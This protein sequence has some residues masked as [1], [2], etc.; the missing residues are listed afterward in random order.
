MCWMIQQC[1]YPS[2]EGMSDMNVKNGILVTIGSFFAW[3]L[4]FG[5]YFILFML[6]ERM[7]NQSGSYRFVPWVRLGYGI[8]WLAVIWV[9]YRSR[10]PEWIKASILAGSLTTFLA[11]IGVLL[12]ET[13]VITGLVIILVAAA[14]FLLRKMN[15]KWYHYYAVVLSIGAALFYP[16]P[17]R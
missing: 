8:A 17:F 2:I 1:F 15:K 5:V 3:I 13:P 11:A 9:T 4:S 10:L 6:F 12:Y 7:E 16:F 14:L